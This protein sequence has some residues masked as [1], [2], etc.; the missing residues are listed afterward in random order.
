V[1]EFAAEDAGE[2]PQ[3]SWDA[4]GDGCGGGLA[5]LVPGAA[6]YS[7]VCF[8]G[9]DSLGVAATFGGSS[10]GGVPCRDFS[11]ASSGAFVCQ[12]MAA[13]DSVLKIL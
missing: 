11:S 2:E 3:D 7:S 5:P 8:V 6:R 13:A 4:K 9:S 10:V 1:L 12:A